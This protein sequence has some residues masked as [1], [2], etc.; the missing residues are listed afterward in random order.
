MELKELNK[1]EVKKNLD[2]ILIQINKVGLVS[3]NQKS[4]ANLSV[5]YCT[6]YDSA[7]ENAILGKADSE[8]YTEKY[9]NAVNKLIE[10]WEK[11]HGTNIS[12]N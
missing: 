1:E 5:E 8:K 6:I 12:A 10:R 9:L 4:F 3:N 2:N 11:T 7:K